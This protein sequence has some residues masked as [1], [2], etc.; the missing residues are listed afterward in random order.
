MICEAVTLEREIPTTVSK[1]SAVNSVAA[2]V[3]TLLDVYRLKFCAI[4]HL[5]SAIAIAMAN[6]AVAP[7]LG[8]LVN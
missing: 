7:A 4:F 8:K 5:Y 3:P 6:P 2:E 1:E